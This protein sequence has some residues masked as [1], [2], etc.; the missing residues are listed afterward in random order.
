MRMRR[1]SQKGVITVVALLLGV[2][3]I[4]AIGLLAFEIGRVAVARDQLRTA[5]EA[6][7][8]AASG[9]L[10]GTTD[11]DMAL[12]QRNAIS[13]AKQVLALNDVLGVRLIDQI[14]GR[15]KPASGQ[16]VIN[17]KFLDP[18]NHHTEVPFG[19]PKGKEI[20][21]DVVFGYTSATGKFIGVAQSSTPIQAIA[22]GGAGDLDVALCFDVSGSMDDAT[23]VSMVRRQF[24]ADKM[25]YALSTNF[26]AL[27]QGRLTVDLHETILNAVP[28]QD[29][30]FESN[31]DPALRALDR[32][33]PPRPPAPA[34]FTDLVVNIDG[35]NSFGGFS[36]GGFDFPNIGTLVEASRGNL[37][38]ADR[39]TSS[40]AET[41][42]RGTV[43][44]RPGYQAKY[45]ELAHKNIHPLADAQ[46]G[47][48]E[49]FNL[50][51]K[52]TDAHFCLV[53]FN[54]TIGS[55]PATTFSR[56][57]IATSFPSGGVGR[58]PL[59]M[60]PLDPDPDD[61]NF[62][63]VSASLANLVAEDG[64]NIAG[65]LDQAITELRTHGR[66][67]AKKV[68]ILFTDGVPTV[69]SSGGDP[70][71]AARRSAQR[72]KNENIAIFTIGLSL[73]PA[74]LAQQ[75]RVL[76]DSNPN[77]VTGGIAAI[78][79]NGGK[80]FQT[81]DPRELKSAFAKVARQLTELVQ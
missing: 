30:Q 18:K 11:N 69:A 6:A 43:T 63:Q 79:G 9:A 41:A 38:S 7:A 4:G 70:E 62:N 3:G 35:N 34:A 77:P 42:L 73:D 44:P 81:S 65:S 72:A 59:P 58:F 31:F 66:P 74:D 2:F 68:I 19:D 21:V 36:D 76:N 14:E 16:A 22:T 27:Q 26:A 25:Q 10:A 24:V 46:E 33:P 32:V 13:A 29:L 15:S 8:L 50:M 80:F 28:P 56:S 5:T 40:G 71:L 48:Q 52:G 54:A 45:F 67:S 1:R 57:N 17:F 49:F 60:V 78:A 39:F 75:F 20:E 37:E 23:P 61:T 47:S 12:S 53:T 51:N 55:N 64:T